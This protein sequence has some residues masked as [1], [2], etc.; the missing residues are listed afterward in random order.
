MK[1]VTRI[2]EY[3]GEG[4]LRNR[5]IALFVGMLLLANYLMFCLHA[6]IVPFDVFPC[7]TVQESRVEKTLYLPSYSGEGLLAEERLFPSFDDEGEYVRYLVDQVCR[8]SRM[9]NT[10]SLV[11]VPVHVRKVW[12]YPA[13]GSSR[14]CII[15]VDPGIVPA[16][17]TLVKGSEKLFLE[18]LEKNIT[19]HVNGVSSVSLLVAGI[20][21]GTI[22]SDQ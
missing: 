13:Q 17:A 4:P 22:W 19:T 18:A 11:P 6:G 15:D 12:F 1:P 10:A 3:F 16:D 20:P 7:I 8:G 9:E 14:Q 21:G 2:K 5:R